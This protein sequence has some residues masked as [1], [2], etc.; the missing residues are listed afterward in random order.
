MFRILDEPAAAY[1]DNGYV[2]ERMGGTVNVVDSDDPTK[3]GKWIVIAAPSDKI[4]RLSVPQGELGP[5]AMASGARPRTA[6]ATAR[7]RCLG[8]ALDAEA[9]SSDRGTASS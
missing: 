2:R 3:D 6:I 4:F 8:H 1:D 9:S 7:G 5:R